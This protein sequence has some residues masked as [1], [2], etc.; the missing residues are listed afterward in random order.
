[1]PTTKKFTPAFQA[2]KALSV[3]F[4]LKEEFEALIRLP[5]FKLEVRIGPFM[6]QLSHELRQAD[7]SAAWT[8]LSEFLEE[9]VTLEEHT[10][11]AVVLKQLRAETNEGKLRMLQNEKVQALIAH[12]L[13]VMFGNVQLSRAE[14]VKNIADNTTKELIE[15]YGMTAQ[16]ANYDPKRRLVRIAVKLL[17]QL[18]QMLTVPK[19]HAEVGREHAEKSESKRGAI[20]YAVPKG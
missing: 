10:E 7:S 12:E 6:K 20:P 13:Q 19:T 11:Q 15:D 9:L 4:G 2:A 8:K 14:H 3:K 17:F 18:V 1:M 16:Q 5:G